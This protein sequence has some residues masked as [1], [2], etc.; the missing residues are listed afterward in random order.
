MSSGA[1]SVSAYVTHGVF[2]EPA[3]KRLKDSK[4]K[5]LVTTNTIKKF[6]MKK[7]VKSEDY[8]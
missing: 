2:S 6:L 5:E 4:L 3:L 7:I 1:K 8:L